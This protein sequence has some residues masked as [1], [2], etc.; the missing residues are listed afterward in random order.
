MEAEK[1]I[2]DVVVNNSFL[3][4]NIFSYA[5]LVSIILN[6]KNCKKPLSKM[7]VAITRLSN[8]CGTGIR[9]P[10]TWARTRRLAIRRSRI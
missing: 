8:C 9:T 6:G 1:N 5:E 7:R 2:K 4:K 3:V 10:I